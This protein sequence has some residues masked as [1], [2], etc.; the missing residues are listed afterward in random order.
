MTPRGL[1]AATLWGHSVAV[2]S[3]AER[4]WS[5]RRPDLESRSGLLMA[6]F[7]CAKVAGPHVHPGDPRLE[8][9]RK[10]AARLIAEL[11]N[12]GRRPRGSCPD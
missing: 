10:E 8:P 2:P 4:V 6:L 12:L 1:A 3:L 9:A 7:F 5:E 11:H